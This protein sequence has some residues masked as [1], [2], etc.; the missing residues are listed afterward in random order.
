M[1]RA[2]VCE[3]E[4]VCAFHKGC[5]GLFS[6]LSI[7]NKMWLSLTYD[8]HFP[9]NQMHFKQL[10]AIINAVNFPNSKCCFSSVLFFHACTRINTAANYGLFLENVEEC[11]RRMA[12]CFKLSNNI[13]ENE[14]MYGTPGSWLLLQAVLTGERRELNT[15][16]GLWVLVHWNVMFMNSIFLPALTDMIV[17]N[18]SNPSD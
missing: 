17:A 1:H 16:A 18:M 2:W 3:E 14:I 12:Q 15:S 10:A 11:R 5:Q 7:F 4:A 6:L 8:L 9:V 13:Q